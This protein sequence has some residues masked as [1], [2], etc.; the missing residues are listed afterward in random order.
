MPIQFNRDFQL[1]KDLDGETSYSFNDFSNSG[2]AQIF[3]QANSTILLVSSLGDSTQKDAFQSVIKSFGG[4]ASAIQS[5]VCIT[6]S[7]GKSSFFFKL[8]ED[9]KL[10]TYKGDKNTLLELWEKYKYFIL[11]IFLLLIVFSFF[12]VRKRVKKSQ[13]IV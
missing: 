10:V 5:N 9:E 6:T 8:R 11:I 13:E 12:F 3:R 7:D 2:I 1:Y 4:Q